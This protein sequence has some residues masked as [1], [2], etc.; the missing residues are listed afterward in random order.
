M[1]TMAAMVAHE[2]NNILTPI[3][4]YARM[5]QKN[6][7][8]SEKALI[9]AADGSLRATN[10]CHA[11]LSATHETNKA[12]TFN[13]AK[14]V[15]STLDAMARRPEKDNIDLQCNIPAELEITTRRVELEQVLLNLLLNARSAVLATH[16]SRAITLTAE[17]QGNRLTMQISDNGCGIA[18]EHV[19]QIFEP[20]FSTKSAE[21][22]EDGF[23]LG[24][25][26]CKEALGQ[27]N[28]EI[29]VDSAPDLGT[30]FTITL[31][32]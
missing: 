1:G 18:P 5:A 24:L 30:T 20:F 27:M 19:D 4:N 9:H 7:A 2:F 3:G 23:G 16:R 21:S 26:F 31:P 28:G 11:L 6:P 12:E 8:L 14:L 17:R 10:I 22:G 32:C 15:Q 29:S 25:A 13:L